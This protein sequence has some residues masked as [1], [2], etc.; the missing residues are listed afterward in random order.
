MPFLPDSLAAWRTGN[1]A[2]TLARELA[3]LPPD[4]LP[5]P[6]LMGNHTDDGNRQVMILKVTEE[7][8]TIEVD[9][10]VFFEEIS[11]GCSCGDEPPSQPAYG[12]L[13][14]TLDKQTA[15]AAFRLRPS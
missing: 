3:A 8:D 1:F 13:S 4:A 11:A 10:G 12:E 15:K 5:L 6:L 14:L 2:A 9:I 7:N